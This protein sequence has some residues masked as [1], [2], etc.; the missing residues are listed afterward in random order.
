MS[1]ELKNRGPGYGIRDQEPSC[2]I[3]DPRIREPRREIKSRVAKT[4]EPSDVVRV[5]RAKKPKNRV[6]NYE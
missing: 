2:G 5:T 3:R 4:K 1:Y 6:M